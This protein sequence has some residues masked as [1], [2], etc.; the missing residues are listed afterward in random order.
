LTA[1]KDFFTPNK[2][3]PKLL[4]PFISPNLDKRGK[5][6][7]NKKKEKPL[8]HKI[9]LN[10]HLLGRFTFFFSHIEMKRSAM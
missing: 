3:K 5:G 4:K 8:L 2:I 10:F 9:N 1:I 7:Q 6:Q